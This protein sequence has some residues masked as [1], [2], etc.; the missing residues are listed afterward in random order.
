LIEKEVDEKF[1]EVEVSTK[2]L[3]ED[4]VKEREREEA[5]DCRYKGFDE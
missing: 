1:C 5:D 2:F 3:T 4:P